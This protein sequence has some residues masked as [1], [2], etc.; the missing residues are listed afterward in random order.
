MLFI[1]DKSKLF[2][3]GR[4]ERRADLERGK[5]SDAR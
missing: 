3:G 4:E 2:P 1:I 5:G